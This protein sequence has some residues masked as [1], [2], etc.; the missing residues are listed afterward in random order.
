MKKDFAYGVIVF[1]EENE[2]VYYL[3]LKQVQGHWSF[4]KGHAEKGETEMQTALRELE[5]ET[6]ITDVT[7]VSEGQKIKDEYIIKPDSPK[8]INKIVEFYIGQVSNK[9]V[10]MQDGEIFEFKWITAEEGNDILTYD[11][12]KRILK[13]ANE[14]VKNYLQKKN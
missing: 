10:T 4:P 6:G 13:S 14:L 12:S 3:I 2:T 8:P 11:S 7:L 5:E 9:D 1:Y